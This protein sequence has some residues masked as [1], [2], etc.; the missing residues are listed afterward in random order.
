M[1]ATGDLSGA[2]PAGRVLR[3]RWPALDE[4]ESSPVRQPA[5]RR[6]AD[7]R[8][9]TVGGR[10]GPITSATHDS[11]RTT[12]HTRSPDAPPTT[13]RSPTSGQPETLV[14]VVRFVVGAL[15][16]VVLALT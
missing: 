14:L 9:A 8:D 12:I 16:V 3:P 11:T 5:P 10:A 13:H 15:H 4:C 2:Q 7:E 1:T 6:T